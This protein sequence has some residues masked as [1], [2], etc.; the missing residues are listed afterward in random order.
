MVETNSI[1]Q[2]L[3]YFKVLET[4]V[5][6]RDA[7]IDL[8]ARHLPRARQI[9]APYTD[10]QDRPTTGDLELARQLYE[11]GRCAIAHAHSSPLIDPDDPR[12]T[13]AIAVDAPLVRSLAEVVIE[14]ELKVS[15]WPPRDWLPDWRP[16]VTEPLARPNAPGPGSR[17]S[18]SNFK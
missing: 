14:G 18:P 13:R 10:P 1:F 8:A 12:N 4:L 6:G 3:S 9:A 16:L 2:Y 11:E 15:R 5:S 17:H 7:I